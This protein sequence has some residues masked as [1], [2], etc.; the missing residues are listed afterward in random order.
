MRKLTLLTTLILSGFFCLG[1]WNPNTSVNLEVAT[2]PVMD[3]QSLTTTSGKTW[4]AFYHNNNGNYDMRAQLLDT[5]GTKLLGPDG[6][7]VDN[8]PSGSATFVFNICKDAN[9]NLVVA[10]QD[11]RSG[12]M[13]AVAYKISQ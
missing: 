12:N 4:V 11:Q 10:Y 7:L 5:D 3:M 13:S 9:D 8:K 1:Q 2:V 6:M